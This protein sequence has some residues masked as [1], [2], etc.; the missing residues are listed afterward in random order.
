[1]DRVLKFARKT[2]LEDQLQ[3]AREALR[4]SRTPSEFQARERHIQEVEFELQALLRM[5]GGE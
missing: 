1:M 5:E 2:F 4:R 3:G